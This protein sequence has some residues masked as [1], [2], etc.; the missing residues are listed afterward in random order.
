MVPRPVGLALLALLA[1][2][3][4][5][6]R[7]A[8]AALDAYLSR[9]SHEYQ[10]LYYESGLAEWESNTRIVEGD[11]T[12]SIRTRRANEALARFVGS[13]DNIARIQEYLRDRDRLSP[14]QA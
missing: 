12:N 4:G 2:Q 14:V 7:S 5:T 10:R 9:Y 1:C 11:S 3:S 8:N 13:N 6:S